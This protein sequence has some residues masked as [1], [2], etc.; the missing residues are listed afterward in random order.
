MP[1]LPEPEQ[2]Y[3]AERWDTISQDVSMGDREKLHGGEDEDAASKRGIQATTANRGT[4]HWRHQGESRIAGISN[5]RDSR[6][7]D[8]VQS[9]LCSKESK[10]DLVMS[11]EERR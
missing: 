5:Q 6:G 1:Y 11:P 2:M 10:E 3:K 7:K 9:G 4:G 8:R